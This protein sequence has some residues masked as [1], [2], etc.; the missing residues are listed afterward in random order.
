VPGLILALALSE[1]C[2]AIISTF[3]V[4][5]AGLCVALRLGYRLHIRRQARRLKEGLEH[6]RLAILRALH[7][8]EGSATAQLDALER[9]LRDGPDDA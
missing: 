2:T 1:N 5:L 9:F 3:T 4:L 8:L 7:D 6:E